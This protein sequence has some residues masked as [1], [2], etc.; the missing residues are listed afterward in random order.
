MRALFSLYGWRYAEVIVYML[1]S[2]E[3]KVPAYLKWLHRTKDF[4]KVMYRRKLEKTRIARLLM[5]ALRVG[6]YGQLAVGAALAVLAYQTS[7]ILLSV[8]SLLLV[9]SFPLVWAYLVAVPLQLGRWLVMNPKYRR[10]IKASEKIFAQ[11]QAIKIAVAGSYGKTSMK[12]LLATVLS[13]GKKVAA[14]PANKN[15][16][17]SHARFAQRLHGDED[18]LVIEYG[19]GGP[20]DVSRFA[21]ITHPDVG[22]ITGLAP[23]HLDNYPSLQ[24]AGEDIFSLADFVKPGKLY[25]N[26]DSAATQSFVTDAMQLYTA[27]EVLGWKISAIKLSFTGT[28]FIMKKGKDSLSLRSGLL[29]R[30]QVGPLGLVAALSHELGLSKQQIEAGVSKTVAFEHRMQPRTIRGAWILDD[31]YNGN[32][33]GMKAGLAL[34]KELPGKRKIYVTPGLVD[35]GIEAKPVHEELGQAIAEANPHKVVLMYNSATGDIEQGLKDGGF[36]GELQ[37][38]Y[39]P[40]DFYLNLEHFIAAGDVTMLQ[41]DWTD[42]YN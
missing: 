30:H 31:T 16:A 23:A 4:S 15:V 20:G 7:N 12:E 29:G 33:D 10:E 19:E 24:A 6:M 26:S 5:L 36:K 37:V 18:I 17:I 40:L 35:Q 22:I 11:H 38:E 14:T 42:N 1:Q 32:I 28:T 13:E 3:Y 39:H 41:N 8:L 2:T 34:L 27:E 21:K 9:V 25:V